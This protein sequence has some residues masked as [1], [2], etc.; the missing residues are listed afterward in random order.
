M[1]EDDKAVRN[2]VIAQYDAIAPVNLGYV[3]VKERCKWRR[4]E[5]W[6]EFS[7]LCLEAEV[8]LRV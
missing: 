1:I 6:W 2:T 8:R 4:R 5:R 7:G 3:V